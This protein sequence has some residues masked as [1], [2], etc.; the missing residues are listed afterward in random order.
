[1]LRDKFE[2]KINKKMGEHE[3]IRQAH[4][5]DHDTEIT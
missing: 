5:P 4:H 3:L 1:M 2:K